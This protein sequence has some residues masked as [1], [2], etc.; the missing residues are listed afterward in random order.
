MEQKWLDLKTASE[1]MQASA[2]RLPRLCTVS[3]SLHRPRRSA[4]STQR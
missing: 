1:A 2:I 4:L 3:L